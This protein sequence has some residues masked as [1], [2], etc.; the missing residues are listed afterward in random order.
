MTNSPQATDWH[1]KPPG[2]SQQTCSIC[3]YWAKYRGEHRRTLPEEGFSRRFLQRRKVNGRVVIEEIGGPH[4]GRLRLQSRT[5]ERIRLAAELYARGLTLVQIAAELEVSVDTVNNWHV[6]HRHVWQH[7][8]RGALETMEV[9][10]AAKPAPPEPERNTVDRT[11]LPVKADRPFTEAQEMPL[12]VFLHQI[13]IPSRIGL[14][15]ESIK[16]MEIA[17]RQFEKW[18]RR[19]VT[20]GELSEDLIRG[21]MTDFHKD[22]AGATVNSKRRPLVSLRQCAFDEEIIDRPLRKI[23]RAKEIPTIP[24]AWTPGEVGRIMEAA[25]R[26]RGDIEGIP[27]RD[28]WESIL[29]VLYDT[30]E[31]R[32]AVLSTATR[33]LCLDEAHIVFKN[34]KT[35]RPRWA[36]LHLETV[37]ACRRIYDPDRALMWPW[38]RTRESL[39]KRIRVILWR[40]KVKFGKGHGGLFH[41]LRRTSGTLVE[42]AGLDGS[43]H[44]GNT[45]AVFES[46]YLDPRFIPRQS[47]ERLPR[48][49]PTTRLLTYEEG[50][51]Q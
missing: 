15:P 26:A 16:Q 32:G 3:G 4:K 9:E 30:G 13:Y 43:K 36:P 42:A 41:K 33:D 20:I 29:L 24:E 34:T 14:K 27:T 10:E 35:G 8:Y 1:S 21:F 6:K 37:E 45:R 17:I 25:R 48:P 38:S 11:P 22:R 40:A 28:W 5:R 2:T 19:T 18:A 31:R 44:I 51:Q 47:L 39:E 46:N 12:F 23:R 49:T 50:P 7:D